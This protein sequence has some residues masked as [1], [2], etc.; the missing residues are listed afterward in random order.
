MQPELFKPDNLSQ[1][2]LQEVFDA[3]LLEI[4]RDDDGD[5]VVHDKYRV[6]VSPHGDKFIRFTAAF[7]IKE[8]AGEEA[9]FALCNRINDGLVVIRASIHDPTTLVIDWYLPVVGGI[10][11]KAVVRA[12]RTF[13]E[14]LGEMGQYDTDDI[15]E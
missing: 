14:L 12:V 3:A 15:I 9:S 1:D 7:G 4:E 2:A 8:E 10:T 11:K 6:I 5:V 13:N